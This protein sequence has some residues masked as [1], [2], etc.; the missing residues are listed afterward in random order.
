MIGY[1]FQFALGVFLFIVI[2]SVL[3]IILLLGVTTLIYL[4]PFGILFF[5]ISSVSDN[6][7][8]GLFLAFLITYFLFSKKARNDFS[9][10]F[11]NGITE[12][13]STMNFLIHN[14]K[15][16]VITSII[17][18]GL[19]Y[20]GIYSNNSIDPNV[21]KFNLFLIIFV[22]V[23]V[24]FDILYLILIKKKSPTHKTPP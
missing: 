24:C 22:V 6:L 17:F 8:I 3:P 2:L 11:K 4:I 21:E 9:K 16:P 15:I 7:L 23:F 5:L 13:G 19:I 18:S 12:L 20:L 14:I 1:G 10:D